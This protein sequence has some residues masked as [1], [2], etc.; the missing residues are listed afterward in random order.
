MYH[1]CMVEDSRREGEEM[2]RKMLFLCIAY[3]AGVC[4]LAAVSVV[5]FLAYR[6]I[7][8][9]V[10]TLEKAHRLLEDRYAADADVLLAELDTT[11]LGRFRKWAGREHPYTLML[12]GTVKIEQ[13]EYGEAIR[14]LSRSRDVCTGE[15]FEIAFCEVLG[16]EALFRMGNAS[17]LRWQNKAFTQAVRHFEQGLLR[18]SDDISAKKS[19][20][21]LKLLEEELEKGEKEKGQQVNRGPRMF[22]K[23]KESSGDQK[24]RKGF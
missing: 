12:R 19:L 24:P 11:P 22:E 8:R 2:R 17:M 16:A 5:S 10:E 13:G 14:Y 15:R 4:G 23:Q 9:E 6:E 21:W 20:E 7:L 18:Q 3:I 1:A